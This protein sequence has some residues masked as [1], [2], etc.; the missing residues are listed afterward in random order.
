M[1]DA[2]HKLFRETEAAKVL[3]A[4]IA[5]LIEGDEECA[6]DMVAG[7]TSLNEAIEAAVSQ[8]ADDMSKI[9]GLNDYIEQ[10]SNRKDRLQERVANMRAA[11]T[12]AM[13]QAGLKKFD[14]CA[15]TLSLRN[16]PPAV[17]VTNEALIPSAYFKASEPRLDKRAV[18]AA[19]KAKETV[20]GAS[21][22][23]GGTSLAL[24]WS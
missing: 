23:N 5:D 12:V 4:Q 3:R 15:V 14:H 19:L 21:L 22:N 6:A 20:P 11:L 9:K 7:E 17:T 2:G 13:E 24:T 1:S 18:L 8:L 10:F 16:T